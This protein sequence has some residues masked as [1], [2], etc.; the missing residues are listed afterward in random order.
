MSF[1]LKAISLTT[2]LFATLSSSAVSAEQLSVSYCFGD[3]GGLIPK[4][5]DGTHYP[6]SFHVD[7]FCQ[8]F[9]PNRVIE[10]TRNGLRDIGIAH[11]SFAGRY[12]DHLGLLQYPDTFES[13][14]GF[15]NFA[16]SDEAKS[17]FQEFEKQANV[18]FLGL[19]YLGSRNLLSKDTIRPSDKLQGKYIAVLPRP[20]VIEL[21]REQ[22]GRTPQKAPAHLGH[23]LEMIQKGVVD[24]VDVNSVELNE[25]WRG[26]RFIAQ[27]LNVNFVRSS[28][29]FDSVIFM[30]NS[31]SFD[32]LPGS[33][34]DEIEPTFQRITRKLSM[35]ALDA[36]TELFKRMSNSPLNYWE[37]AISA[38][39]KKKCGGTCPKNGACP[40]QFFAKKKKECCPKNG[41]CTQ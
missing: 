12:D 32:S 16:S 14:E 19:A 6:L 10:G 8:V 36:E 18:K 40:Q 2:L 31:K 30:M 7:G 15:I 38:K 29:S 35:L 5:F 24:Y 1:N 41:A 22:T 39:K 23:R 13:A 20:G 37:G 25:F 34:R 4:A 9:K 33:K 17:L 26:N 3:R 11:S 27:N 21:F 28:H